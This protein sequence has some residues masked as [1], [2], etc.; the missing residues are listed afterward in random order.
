[1]DM[2]ARRPQTDIRNK[3]GGVKP[4]VASSAR[5][6]E[7]SWTFLTNHAHV[8]IMLALEKGLVLREIAH[9]VGITERA[10][11]K[12]IGELADD[13]Y[14]Q[15][16]RVGRRNE[17]RLDLKRPLRHAIEQHRTIGDVIAL[18]QGR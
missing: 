6:A 1:V 16:V 3:R 7:S 13:G 10:V 18:I 8:L 17:Y 14:L 4:S 11:Q 2:R 5:E 12:I 15:R 9:R